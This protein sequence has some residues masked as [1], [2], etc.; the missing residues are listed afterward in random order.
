MGT[1]KAFADA[2]NGLDSVF[3]KA[4]QKALIK[5]SDV[6]DSEKQEVT[7]EVKQS[8]NGLPQNWSQPDN[9]KENN[10]DT[11][12]DKEQKNTEG[13][14]GDIVS[15]TV[16]DVSNGVNNMAKT[17][18]DNLSPLGESVG[19]FV[20][21]INPF[22]PKPK[23]DLGVYD[24]NTLTEEDIK[25]AQEAGYR[26]IDDTTDLSSMTPYYEFKSK[27][28]DGG[29][30]VLIPYNLL[31]DNSI[32]TPNGA[33]FFILG[34]GPYNGAYRNKTRNY[35]DSFG[36]TRDQLEEFLSS[37]GYLNHYGT[38]VDELLKYA[39]PVYYNYQ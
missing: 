25:R 4:L 37:S 24:P 14:F 6:S 7:N 2:N 8:D 31:K 28:T 34:H 13:S 15:K 29:D 30:E 27:E 18:Y 26:A 11:N 9:I 35:D 3:M 38:T 19:S 5:Q 1:I 39:K 36:G 33:P 23:E 17:V 12:E 16:N 32:G 10:P 20:D 22:K 21:S